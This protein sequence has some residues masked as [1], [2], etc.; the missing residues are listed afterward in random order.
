MKSG[1]TVE[2]RGYPCF[3]N[4][5]E[6][7]FPLNHGLLLNTQ[8]VLAALHRLAFFIIPKALCRGDSHSLLFVSVAGTDREPS[9]SRMDSRSLV[10]Y[11]NSHA[12]RGTKYIKRRHW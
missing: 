3:I 11:R 4:E 1:F 2:I 8:Y 12:N 10:P 6:L 9:C 5:S 7:L